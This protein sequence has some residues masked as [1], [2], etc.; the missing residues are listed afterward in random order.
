MGARREIEVVVASLCALFHGCGGCG[1]DVVTCDTDDDCPLGALCS[2]GACRLE[3]PSNPPPPR[4]DGGSTTCSA[5]DEPCSVQVDCCNFLAGTGFCVEQACADTCF[6][7]ADC[8][9]GCC[10][11]VDNGSR[12]C[13]AATF[14]TAPPPSSGGGF[15]TPWAARVQATADAYGCDGAG[16]PVA[17]YEQRCNDFVRQYVEPLGCTSSYGAYLECSAN[18]TGCNPCRGPYC[19]WN[20]C[21]CAASGNDPMLC[22][23]ECF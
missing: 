6:V 16:T 5:V 10:A 8:L 11:P 12:V 21:M 13:S 2:S 14:C 4:P 9:S 7:D 23:A 18:A 3:G 19:T 20:D 1:D 22:L 15:C 17:D